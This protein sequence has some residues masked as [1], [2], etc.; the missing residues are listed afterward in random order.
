[1]MDSS[2]CLR[3]TRAPRDLATLVTIITV[4]TRVDEKGG[5][6]ERSSCS[7]SP[8]PRLILWSR[9][10]TARSIAVFEPS[11]YFS[12][13]V[14]TI[15]GFGWFT[16]CSQLDSVV[17]V[18]NRRNA[19]SGD[20]RAVVIGTVGVRMC[21]YIFCQMLMEVGANQTKSQLKLQG[22]NVR[23]IDVRALL[24]LYDTSGVRLADLSAQA[25]APTLKMREILTSLNCLGFILETGNGPVHSAKGIGKPTQNSNLGK[26]HAID[27]FKKMDAQG[28]DGGKAVPHQMI[29]Q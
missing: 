28:A 10:T 5:D 27:V 29:V 14:I 4:L 8:F 20:S 15:D 23:F 13:N 2:K 16:L 11:P 24:G 26:V 22:L 7:L 21:I 9:L 17:V 18:S 1:M 12:V 3:S 6:T 25:S 19:F